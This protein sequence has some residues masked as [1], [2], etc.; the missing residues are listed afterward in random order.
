[1]S[2]TSIQSL[3][4]SEMIR[5][6]R[7]GA[8]SD[9][10]VSALES[11]WM[12]VARRRQLDIENQYET[13]HDPLQ[14]CMRRYWN[15]C[16]WFNGLLPLWWNGFFTDPAGARLVARLFAD[17]DKASESAWA[18][19]GEVSRRLGSALEPAAFNQTSDLDEV[20]NL[21]FDCPLE[22]VPAQL[23]GMFVKRARLRLAL[24]R[25]GGWDLLPGQLPHLGR[26]LSAA[27]AARLA[28]KRL[29]REAFRTV[30]PPL[31]R[32]MAQGL[33]GSAS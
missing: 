6:Q 1:M 11:V 16:G 25:M 9:D 18:L 26:D 7:R 23:S 33:A 31:H 32:L 12:K 28:F 19:F 2:M 27:S 10:D 21:R 17:P 29:G 20:L 24:V 5:R 3:Q 8:L 14:A 22:D 4:I 15:I 30:K 13:M